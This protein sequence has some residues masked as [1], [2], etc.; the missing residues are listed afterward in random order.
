MGNI[1][2]YKIII[3][4]DFFPIKAN[5]DL[6]SKGDIHSLFGEKIVN[7]F[8][9][10]DLRIC[11]LEG[12]LS[13][14]KEK[15]EKTGPVITAPVKAIKAYQELGIDYCMLANNHITDAGNQ[16]VL[17][18]IETLDKVGIRH[19][20]AGINESSI[21][22][23]VIHTLEDKKICIYNVCE[24]MYNKPDGK[25]SGAWLYDEY[26][27]CKEL[28]SLKQQSDYLI[29]IY[30]GGIEKFR[31]PSPELKKRFHRMADSGADV[32]L[33][34]HTHCIGCEEYYNGTYLLYGQGDFLL[35]NFRPEI[36]DKGFIVEL[37]IDSKGLT[38]KKHIV[39]CSK[40]LR[41]SYIDTPDYT[42]FNKR[43]NVIQDDEF[44]NNE[45]KVFCEK[46]LLLYLTAFKSPGKMM[47]FVRRI[48]PDFYKKWLFHN[49]F[50]RRNLL[51][52]LH[53]LRSE[54]N[55][56]TA[57]VGIEALLGSE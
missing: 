9:D 11:N 20:G 8:S 37:D 45:F 13:D 33:S 44:L 55:R 57:I 17:D 35:N 42:D 16:G 25:K 27:V 47:R 19:V 14:G 46:E 7:L 15:C 21:P 1:N 41:L 52:T 23:Y 3:V 12:A 2:S 32:I 53:T 48:F 30:H 39:E 36:T 4:G 50:S 24:R 18:T 54:Q 38:I 34:Q 10:A 31:Y 28:E 51:F 43:S 26:V 6:F 5:I 49:A 56:E 22:H 29:V 40:D